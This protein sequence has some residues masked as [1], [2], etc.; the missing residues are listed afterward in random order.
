MN[1][2]D[3][4][5]LKKTMQQTFDDNDAIALMAL[6]KANA[7]LRANNLTWEQVFQR[8]VKVEVPFEP[9]PTEQ[10]ES[11]IINAAF[12]TIEA[13]DPRGSFADFVASLKDQWD[14]KSYLSQK[15]KDA[16]FD[17]AKKVGR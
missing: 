16:L 4:S 10:S 7:V 15:Q 1:L 2:H 5:R 17:A 3:F 6:R 11:A 8:L 14:R 12:E 13:S 9:A